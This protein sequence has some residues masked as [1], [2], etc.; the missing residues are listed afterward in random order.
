MGVLP[1]QL[2]LYERLT[3]REL[4]EFAG[5]LYGLPR[6]ESAPRRRAAAT[7]GLEQTPT[8]SSWTTPSACARRSRW[9]P[10]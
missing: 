4:I 5:R 6:D 10:R 7:L 9:P 2:N 3:G 8:S 1:E